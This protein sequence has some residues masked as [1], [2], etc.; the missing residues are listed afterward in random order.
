MSNTEWRP[1]VG[2]RVAIYGEVKSICLSGLINVALDGGMFDTQPFDLP[3][4]SPLPSAPEPRKPWE[5]LEKA[6]LIVREAG[7][8]GANSLI[9]LASEL[10]AAAPKPPTLAE[11]AENLL[12][13]LGST[14][15]SREVGTAYSALKDALA[16]AENGA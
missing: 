4:L 15:V 5:V 13:A 11:A 12:A 3:E 14:L 8:S 10:K 9:V 16:R 6:A 7:R 2:E 1:K